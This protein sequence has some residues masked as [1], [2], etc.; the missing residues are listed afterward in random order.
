MP[1]LEKELVPNNYLLF[2]RSWN[3]RF[4]IIFSFVISNFF[5]KNKQ[6][7]R[8]RGKKNASFLNFYFSQG[9]HVYLHIYRFHN[10]VVF[11]YTI[12]D[13]SFQIPVVSCSMGINNAS[14][15]SKHFQSLP[16]NTIFYISIILFI[17]LFIYFPLFPYIRLLFICTK[18]Q[19]PPNPV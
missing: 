14:Q 4:Q 12:Y 5:E 2:T 3:R 13:I 11:L 9:H 17:Y 16:V 6:K 8:K 18:A 10:L 1:T 7:K 19:H 15:M